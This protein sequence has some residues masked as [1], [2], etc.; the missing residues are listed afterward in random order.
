MQ[1]NP[2]GDP[3]ERRGKSALL[4]KIVYVYIL[5]DDTKKR[6]AKPFFAICSR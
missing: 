4:R 6:D 3:G 5:K 1:Q 2:P